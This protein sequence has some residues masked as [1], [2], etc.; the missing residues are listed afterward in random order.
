[1]LAACL[2]EKH[3]TSGCGQRGLPTAEPGN[4]EL[5]SCP[6]GWE[7]PGAPR[8]HS[9]LLD[10]KNLGFLSLLCFLALIP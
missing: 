4:P 6:G 3:G 9:V 5:G 8:D 2:E 1:M 10:P 7:G